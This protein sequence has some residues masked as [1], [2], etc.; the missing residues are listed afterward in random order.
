MSQCI[1]RRNSPPPIRPITAHA[2]ILDIYDE[3]PTEVEIEVV[4]IQLI[5]NRIYNHIHMWLGHLYACLRESYPEET[6]TVPPK[7]TICLKLV[8]IIYFMWETKSI[9]AELVCTVLVLIK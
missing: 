3:T 1:N 5:R 6:S 7:P 8:E 4:V 9:P 2:I